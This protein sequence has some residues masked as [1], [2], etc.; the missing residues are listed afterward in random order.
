MKI[1]VKAQAVTLVLG[2]SA[3]L[4]SCGGTE[5]NSNPLC[6][7]DAANPAS[8]LGAKVKAMQEASA[9]IAAEANRLDQSALATCKAM[10]KE[11]SIPDAELLPPVPTGMGTEQTP[12]QA[13]C[14]RVKVEL[15]KHI[16]QNLSAGVKLTVVYTPISCS[17]EASVVSTC[18]EKCDQ[19]TVERRKVECKPGKLSGTCGGQCTG[20]CSGS[21]SGSCQGSCSGTCDA[22]CTGSCD[23][24]CTGTCSGTCNGTCNGTCSAMGADGKCA[25]TCTGTCTGSCGG[26][27]TGGCTGKCS[28][29]CSGKCTGSCSAS[30]TG[31]CSAS[32]SGSCDVMFTA[33]KCEE[34]VYE[35]VIEE[36]KT[37]CDTEARAKAQC[38]P[39]ELTVELLASISPAQRAKVDLAIAV[40][41]KH[42]P[43]MLSIGYKSGTVMSAAV[44]SYAVALKGVIDNATGAVIQTGA[45]LGSAVTATAT[46]LVQVNVSV[47]ASA[48]ITASAS[49]EGTAAASTM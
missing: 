16:A 32:C 1:L 5:G 46:A 10:A 31:T 27:C 13:A 15:D 45:C 18:V 12:T 24:Q 2:I 34:F 4:A 40:L 47:Q 44:A 36:C 25:G 23:A 41:K 43:T 14:A 33:P 38:T 48:S 21:C 11:L 6:T 29:G 9:T 26:T 39:P 30:C 17:A 42:L 37:T 3:L 28:G 35:E 49:A 19:R 8:V 20:N 7:G 22:T